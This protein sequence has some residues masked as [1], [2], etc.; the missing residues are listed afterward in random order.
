[1]STLSAFLAENALTVEHVKFPA[2]KRFLDEEKQ[3]MLWEIKTISATEDEVLRK[4][5]LMRVPVPGR[6][7]QYQ[8]ETDYNKYLGKLAV[9][10]TVF[11][12][13]N[14]TELQDSY[15]VKSGE[16]VLK[17]MLTPGEYAGYISKIQEVCGFDATLQDAVD[18]AKN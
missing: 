9:A 11:P 12:N 5:C 6:K 2:S 16:E 10:C 7:N 4:D 15:H 17:A 18:E 14:S 1:M 8:Q 13:L 3:P